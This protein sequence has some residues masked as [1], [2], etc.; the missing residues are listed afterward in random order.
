MYGETRYLGKHFTWSKIRH[1]K[2]FIG[3]FRL[4]IVQFFSKSDLISLAVMHSGSGSGSSSQSCIGI[5]SYLGSQLTDVYELLRARNWDGKT[6][7]PKSK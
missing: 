7:V 3:I 4:P 5:L 6:N 1:S 2:A